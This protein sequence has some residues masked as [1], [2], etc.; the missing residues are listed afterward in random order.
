MLGPATANVLS[1]YMDLAHGM[2][3]NQISADLSLEER[4]PV[5]RQKSARYVGAW[6]F[7]HLWT[8]VASLNVTH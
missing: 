7:K 8:S 2:W 1:L 5:C 4:S 3:S 6:P